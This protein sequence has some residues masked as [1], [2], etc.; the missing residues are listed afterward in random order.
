MKK[1]SD[2]VIE[3]YYITDIGWLMKRVFYPKKG[4]WINYPIVNIKQK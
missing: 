3:G 4:L 2:V 1:K